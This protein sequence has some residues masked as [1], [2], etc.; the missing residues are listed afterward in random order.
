[1]RMRPAARV[2]GL[3]PRR[4]VLL[5]AIALVVIA[6]GAFGGI[7]LARSG[8]GSADPSASRPSH[9]LLVPGYGGS[10]TALSQLAARIRA[11]GRSATVVPLAGDGTG[12]LQVQAR[13]LNGYVD[14]AVRDGSGPVTVI[15][16]SAG[17][18]VAWLWDVDFK[19]AAKV[20]QFITLGSP[21]H[22]ASLAALGAAFVPGECPTACQQ[23]VPGSALLSAL[24]T[25]P[26]ARPPWL[27]LWTTD[28]QVVEPPASA[29][30]PGAVNVPLQSVCPGVS[31][32]HGQLPTD[33]LVV[34]IVLRDLGQTAPAA[35]GPAQCHSLQAL[36]N[37]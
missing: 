32:A 25:S 35:P 29:R 15:G 11:T 17:G 36:G 7:Q 28:D 4:R 6:L 34:G 31:I 22:G 27:S 14:Q 9:V 13:V 16:Y 30:L 33:P 8:S 12:D 5:V 1:M 26:A 23:L 3:S 21:L 20:R 2:A 37:G 18:V 24:Q 19:A 10:T